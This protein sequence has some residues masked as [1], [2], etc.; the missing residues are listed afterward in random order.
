MKRMLILL[1]VCLLLI[2][3]ALAEEVVLSPN[4]EA[5]RIAVAALKDKYGLTNDLFG[6][7]VPYVASIENGVIVRYL[8]Q[9]YLPANIVGEYEVQIIDGQATPTW[10]HDDQDPMFW[11]S[12]MLDSPCWG[13]KQLNQVRLSSAVLADFIPADYIPVELPDKHGNLTFEWVEPTAEDMPAEEAMALA[14]AAMKAVYNLPPEEIR[15]LDHTLEP[16]M[17][18]A[19][20]GQR[21]WRFSFG[22]PERYFDVMVNAST[23][24]IFAVTITTG[25]NG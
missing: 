18:L 11:Q 25:G 12:D 22:D 16:A 23:G 5:E 9:A 19:S 24:E 2:P 6:L 3:V 13:A 20:D 14:D 1:L 4:M 17:L 8:P 7:F 15:L 21:L 10:T